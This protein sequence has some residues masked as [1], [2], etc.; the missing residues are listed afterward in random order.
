MLAAGLLLLSSVTAVDGDGLRLEFD[1]QMRTRVVATAAAP[2]PLGPFTDSETLVT[3]DGELHGYSLDGRSESALDDALGHGRAVVLSGHAGAITKR[4][5]VGAYPAHPGWLFLRVRYTN[6]GTTPLE[7][8]GY[9]SNRYEF[10]PAH[11]LGEPAFWSYQSASYE[12]RPDWLLPVTPGY[13]RGNYLGMNA[14]DYG[15]GTP[16]LDVWRRDIGVAIGHVELVP[17]LVSLPLQRAGAGNA[18]LGMSVQREF[19]L[20]P[21]AS[22]DTVR[23]FVSVHHGDHFATLRAYSI[24]MQAQGLKINASPA[25]IFE[26]LWCAWGYGRA[27]TPEQVV[28]SLP[29]V[30]QLGFRW[31]V[32]DDGW[33]VAEGDWTPTPAKFPRGDADM[34][35][36]VDRIHAAG[37][38]AQLWWAPLA[39]DPLSRTDREHH[40]WLLQNADGTPRHISWWDSNYL[41]PAYGPVQDDAAAFV[42]KALGEWGFDGLKIDGQHLNAAPPCY[43]KAHGH[44]TPE[45]AA[46]RVP[47]FFRA[48]WNAAQQVRPGAVIEVCPCGTGYS[49]FTMPYLNMTVASDPESSWQVRLK[50]K[51]IKALLGDRSA[52][53]GDFVELSDGATDF[54][55][56][57]GV[58]G[59][60]GSNFAWPG[61]PG[62]KDPKLLLTP[63]RQVLWARWVKLFEQQRLVDGEYLGTLYDI[64]FDVPET[65]V[66]AK[67]QAM[68]YAFYAP[69]FHGRVQLRGL[70]PGRYRI[71]DYVND[72]VLGEVRAPDAT[73]EVDF[74]H[75]LLVEALPQQP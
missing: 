14:D 46:E 52:Y 8:R 45:E 70:Q 65:H 33:Q 60:I 67:G 35:A 25:D 72:R 15:G 31:A 17:K 16:I 42:R 54:A 7:V 68:Y 10:E 28:D 1:A 29:V 75:S 69:H 19:T 73:F 47:E 43:N 36:M 74:E 62:E 11:G 64:G 44:A 71:R 37:M 26:P 66:I 49:F 3:P 55:S 4:V 30:R 32:L 24:L 59:I 58:G 2:L 34:K 6:N 12:N 13:A 63:E 5:E 56:T 40:D 18:Q 20:Q 48:V 27:F 53:F 39:A 21:G 22:F 41:C 61:A 9:A 57:F 38:K 23:S 51:T 50:G